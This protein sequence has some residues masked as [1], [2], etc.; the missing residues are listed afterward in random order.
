MCVVVCHCITACDQ[1]ERVTCQLTHSPQNDVTDDDNDE[2]KTAKH[3]SAAPRK[4]KCAI[5][6][7]VQNGKT[8][9]AEKT[10]H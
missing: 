2:D 3:I 5:K 4:E 6:K 7:D 10:S 1:Q 9:T 8:T